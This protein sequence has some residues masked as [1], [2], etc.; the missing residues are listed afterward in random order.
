MYAWKDGH[1]FVIE[2]GSII[3]RKNSY[4]FL[5]FVYVPYVFNASYEIIG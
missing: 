1:S 4:L 5:L 2:L 3:P